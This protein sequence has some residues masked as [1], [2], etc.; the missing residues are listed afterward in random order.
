MQSDTGIGSY[1]EKP[2]YINA[3]GT[4]TLTNITSASFADINHTALQ[5]SALSELGFYTF[6]GLSRFYSAATNT[7]TFYQTAHAFDRLNKISIGYESNGTVSPT[8]IV[9]TTVHAGAF[10][11]VGTGASSVTIDFGPQ[12]QIETFDEPDGPSQYQTQGTKF[13]PNNGGDY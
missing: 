10:Y 5:T 3:S 9:L 4:N 11:K 7:H 8:P 1:L 13:D 2:T 12:N 6:S